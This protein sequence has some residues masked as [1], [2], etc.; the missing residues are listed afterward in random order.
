MA[1]L[2]PAAGPPAALGPRV[3]AAHH[4][5]FLSASAK[6]EPEVLAPA[7]PPLNVDAAPAESV[8]V[9]VI[10]GTNVLSVAQLT[11]PRRYAV[12]EVGGSRGA[13]TS[14]AGD[15]DFALSSERLGTERRE[16]VALRS[17]VPFAVLNAGETPRVLERGKLVDASAALVDCSDVALGARGIELRLDRVV[18]IETSGLTFR[19]AGG[20]KLARVPR[21]V[22][23]STDRSAVFTMGGAA[24]LQGL[25]VAS[26]AYF[27]PSLAWGDDDELNR[28]RLQLMQQ[29]LHASAAREEPPPPDVPQAGGGEKGAPAERNRGPEGAAGKPSAKQ[30][31][32][33][34]IKGDQ[35][36]RVASRQELLAEATQGGLIGMLNAMNASTAPSSPWGADLATGPDNVDAV[37]DMFS[38]NIGEGIGQGGLGLS[39]TGLGGGGN[40]LGI[41]LGRIGTCMGVN[42]YGNGEGGFARSSSLARSGHVTRAPRIATQPLT[43]SGHL[44]PDVIQRVVRQN[45]GRFRNCYEGGLRSNPN[46]EG[47]VTARFVIGR[48]GA[49]SNV[50]AGGDLPDAAVRSCVASAF[51]GLSFPAPDSGIVTVSYPILLTPGG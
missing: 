8:E 6:L 30:A 24:L 27:T 37:G 34:A 50:S 11:P 43:L 31:G 10:W 5:P 32:R 20:E 1:S 47:R 23:G 17:G 26:L 48:D 36:N 22:M 51:Y 25:L 45:F 7:A 18:V 15:V 49:V 33:M 46:L 12:G 13:G 4:N 3:F 38:A 9:T 2:H 44:P 29:Y 21:A 42:C 19:I 14:A 40:G 35:D 16:L 39:G 41:G 28:D